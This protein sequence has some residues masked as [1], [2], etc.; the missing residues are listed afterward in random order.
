MD[1]ITNE[2]YTY[3]PVILEAHFFPNPSNEIYVVNMIR[4][5]KESLDIAI[6]TLTND[7][8]A[9]AI[10]EAFERKIK[11]RII[12][13][14]ECCKMWG[15]DIVRLAAKV[16]LSDNNFTCYLIYIGNSCQN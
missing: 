1:I 14:D 3:K 8:I 7:K 12:A 6:F 4:T 2:Y 10:I 13:D 11:V 9:A 5:C 15:S 16:N